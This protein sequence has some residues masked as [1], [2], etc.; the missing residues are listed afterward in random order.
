M[1]VGSTVGEGV[2]IEVALP[3]HADIC[4]GVNFKKFRHLPLLQLVTLL[5]S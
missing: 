1:C 4:S 2:P 3:D 5:C